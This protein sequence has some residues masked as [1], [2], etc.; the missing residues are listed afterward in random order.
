MVVLRKNPLNGGWK[1]DR[2]SLVT[3]LKF[4]RSLRFL[5]QYFYLWKIIRQKLYL[6]PN[7]RGQMIVIS[8]TIYYK[9]KPVHKYK[10]NLSSIKPLWT[11]ASTCFQHVKY[12]KYFLPL[13]F[14]SFF[15]FLFDPSR[16]AVRFWPAE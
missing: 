5:H 4:L 11:L 12:R 1:R 9:T 3:S 16:F 6:A 7:V 8:F 14:W 10:S 13:F 15:L 2:R